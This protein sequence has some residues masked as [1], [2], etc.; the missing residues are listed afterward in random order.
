MSSYPL[1]STPPSYPLKEIIEDRALKGKSEAGYITTRYKYT[2]QNVSFE[3]NYSM[4]TDADKA[5]LRD[6]YDD[7]ETVDSFTWTDPYTNVSY[8]VRF[9]TVPTF[10][11][12]DN[13]KHECEFLLRV[14]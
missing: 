8:A 3:V 4:L 6:F 1:L 7:V 13:N 11:L 14:I 9:D 5:L 2:R 12:V 10:D